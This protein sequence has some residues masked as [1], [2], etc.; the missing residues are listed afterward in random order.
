MPRITRSDSRQSVVHTE[1]YAALSA[2]G[3]E[4]RQRE[5]KTVVISQSN[6]P[7]RSI[8]TEDI[9][10]TISFTVPVGPKC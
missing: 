1:G 7:Q 2:E 4:T 3:G 8:Q 10:L 5:G 6:A 9:G